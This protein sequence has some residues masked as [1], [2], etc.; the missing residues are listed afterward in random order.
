MDN[1]QTPILA[2]NHNDLIVQR[3]EREARGAKMEAGSRRCCFHGLY[4]FRA[5]VGIADLLLEGGV[6]GGKGSSEFTNCLQ[7]A[8]P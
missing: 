2:F 1:P 5:S 4:C 8:W 3:I 6:G 7:G